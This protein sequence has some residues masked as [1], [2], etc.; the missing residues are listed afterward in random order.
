[1]T[2]FHSFRT[3]ANKHSQKGKYSDHLEHFHKDPESTDGPTG[4][5]LPDEQ[6]TTNRL[7]EQPEIED[8]DS[9]NTK[10]SLISSDQTVCT[11]KEDL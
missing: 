10:H 8:L 6:T 3:E 11:C 2:H 4:G 9:D 5:P 1:M 7:T